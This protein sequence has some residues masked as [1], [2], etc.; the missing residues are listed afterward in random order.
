MNTDQLHDMLQKAKYKPKFS[1]RPFI[2]WACI[3]DM[4]V[5]ERLYMSDKLSQISHVVSREGGW[6][7]EGGREGGQ[8]HEEQLQSAA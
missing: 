6:G 7:R 2:P 1:L 3:I 4:Y 5:W 8:K